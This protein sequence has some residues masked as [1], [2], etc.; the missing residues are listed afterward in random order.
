MTVETGDGLAATVGSAVGTAPAV[1]I[2]DA[3][4]NPVAGVSVTFSVTGGGGN[5]TDPTPTTDDNGVAAAT[6]WSVGDAAVMS[7]TGTFANTLEAAS[8]A[9]TVTFNARAVY[10]YGTHVQPIWDASCAGC[11]GTSG[12]LSLAAPSHGNLV[13]QDAACDGTVKRVAV[14]GGTAAEANSVLMTKMDGTTLAGC[15]GVMPTGGALPEA[16]RDIV[17]AWIRNSAPNN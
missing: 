3:F 1:R 15:S 8:S 16:T 5:V 10:S 6:S 13:D 4:T 2:T 17:R 11:H 14:G 7:D 9:G 12:G